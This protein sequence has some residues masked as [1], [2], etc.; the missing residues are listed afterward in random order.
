MSQV[1]DQIQAKTVV[2]ESFV[3]ADAAGN[4]RAAM[5]LSESDQPVIA[6]FDHQGVMRAELGLADDQPQLTLYDKSG[7]PRMMLAVSDNMSAIALNHGASE[8]DVGIYVKNSGPAVA[9]SHSH[10]HVLKAML[11]VDSDGDPMIK[12]CDSDGAERVTLAFTPTQ[13]PFLAMTDPNGGGVSLEPPT[14]SNSDD[15]LA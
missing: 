13:S 10:D 5:V 4:R 11:S 9:L 8:G 2:A 14:K 15:S 3:L 12:L 6:M 7:A 1:P